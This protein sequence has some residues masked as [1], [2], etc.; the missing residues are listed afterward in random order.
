MGAIPGSATPGNIT[1]GGG[2]LAVTTGY[3]MSSNRGVELTTATSSTIDV[4]SSQ[5][6]FY[7]GIIA[8]SGT[9]EKA[10]SG[11]LSLSGINSFSGGLNFNAGTINL[12][13]STTT[14][15]T[16]S[17]TMANGTTILKYNFIWRRS[18]NFK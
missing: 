4:A 16:G 14:L 18:D 9:L 1:L 10:N 2:T 8:G 17:V 6:L 3:T 13:S 15:G 7:G 11:I 5:T 12:E